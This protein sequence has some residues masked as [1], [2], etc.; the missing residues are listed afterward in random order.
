MSVIKNNP[1]I[2]LYY[3]DTDSG[4]I[5]GD[6]PEDIIDSKKLG[7]WS[8]EN[9]YIYSAFLGP[10]TYGC[11]DIKGEIYSKI[12]GYGSRL[13][14][15]ELS[16]ILSED[17]EKTPLNQIKWRRFLT[18]SKILLK[19]TPYDLICTSNK[20][21]LIYVDNRLTGTE[22]KLSL[23]YILYRVLVKKLQIIN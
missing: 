23:S 3:T 8:L 16:N 20:R 9:E 10:K 2:K 1:L 12:K 4:F 19:T 6:L 18:E 5:E 14:L 17:V 22:N 15:S 21:E 7:Y 11:L 13:A